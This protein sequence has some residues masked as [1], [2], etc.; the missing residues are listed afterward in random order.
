MNTNYYEF[1]L[2][3][4]NLRCC[5]CCKV[6]TLH[7]VALEGRILLSDFRSVCDALGFSFI[8]PPITLEID[9]DNDETDEVHAA[10]GAMVVY[11]N[12]VAAVDQSNAIASGASSSSR[13]PTVNDLALQLFKSTS[14]VTLE[15]LEV[16]DDESVHGPESPESVGVRDIE[17]ASGQP[18]GRGRGRQSRSTGGI[19]ATVRSRSS[20]RL[21][22]CTEV[23][24]ASA[25]ASD[26]SASAASSQQLVVVCAQQRKQL[27]IKTRSQQQLQLQVKLLK[28]KLSKLEVENAQLKQIQSN[29]PNLPF[30]IQKRGRQKEGKAGRF[31]RSSWFAMAIRKCLTNMA[32]CDFGMAALTD[33]SGSTVL[34]SEVGNLGSWQFVWR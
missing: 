11:D 25:S 7:G 17:I 29:D 20:R 10:D 23:S 28:R 1:G 14:P 24:T 4:L 22:I 16:S 2:L 33:V 21:S 31:T 18:R 26:A 30:A 3:L 15:T 8:L 9:D 13:T 5:G 19:G 12:A 32:A 6:T 34:R 27:T